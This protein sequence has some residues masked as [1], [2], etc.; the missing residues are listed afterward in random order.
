MADA[1][2]RI[3]ITAQ[4]D[5][6]A[7]FKQA[8]GNIAALQASAAQL[9]GA[10][11]GAL[12]AGGLA[13]VVTS[14]ID[15]AD[16]LR[17][18]S[19]TT[20]VAI[21]G[22]GGL[23][24]AASQN[25]GS[26]EGV[27]SAAGKLNRTLAEAAAGSKQA[28]EP[29]RALGISIQ[30]AA[31]QTKTADVVFAEVADRFKEFADGP[32]KSALAMRLFG[33][34][35]AEQI[36]LLNEGGEAL[37]ANIEYYKQFS[38]VNAELA[39]SA[40]AFND[41]L[42]KIRLQGQSLGT[43]I[44][45]A[46]LPAL[47]AVADEFLSLQEEGGG[48]QFIANAARIAFEAIAIVGANVI[49]VLKAF[50]REIGAIA[51]QLVALA[52]L[53]IQ[54]F[55]AIS[56]AVKADGVRARAELDALERRI[57]GIGRIDPN[58]ESAAERRRLGLSNGAQALRPAPRLTGDGGA[59]AAREKRE[60]D[61]TNKALSSYVETLE[62][63]LQKNQNLT[64]TEQALIF[65]REKG[66]GATLE[67]AASVL[68]LARA[69]DQEAEQLDRIRLK[70]QLAIDAGN[71]VDRANGERAQRLQALL[72]D[73]PT[74]KFEEQRAS[75]ELLKEAFEQFRNT[76]GQYGI[77]EEQY[78]QAVQKLAGINT[79]LEK[80]KSLG[81]E[82]GLTFTSA[83]EDAIVGGRSFSEILKGLE[84]DVLRIVTRQLVTKPLGDAI[85]GAVSGSGVGGFFSN[86]FSGIFGTR[87]AGGPVQAGGTYLVGERG[88]ELFKA[89]ASGTI[90]PNSQLAG[91]MGGRQMVIHINP[92][93][94][95]SRQGSSQFAADV[96][97]Q[98]RQADRYN[99]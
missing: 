67:Q 91:A 84:Q 87:A 29:F 12:A 60:I 52:R 69:L 83:F 21:Q 92:P 48:F 22:L 11:G 58:D 57:L 50:G 32:E 20:G 10:F 24:F 72:A 86:I 44:A 64:N 75:L 93:P 70:Q 1:Q 53:D 46:L 88:P 51:A 13:A 15:A 30:D 2:A 79:E 36:A 6:A 95:M 85:S 4:D 65:L 66:A 45:A 41:T 47:Q 37:R 76:G 73:T 28:L 90:V 55:N 25:G 99:N 97:R 5:T 31:G 94:G 62:R 61:L 49:F 54:G 89:P 27:A 71:E 74:A 38:K 17:D 8:Q 39:A 7:A 23:G 96:A 18:L 98:L 14:A 56:E 26:L 63:Q 77:S 68:A 3:R 82:L 9:A 35:G 80:S 16:N 34:A 59:K 78:T 19:Q 40:D 81:E 33:K 42:G 43:T